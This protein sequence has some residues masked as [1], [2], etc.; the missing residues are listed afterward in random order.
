MG[1]TLD[2]RPARVGAGDRLGLTLFFAAAL[3][4]IIILGISFR[5]DDATPPDVPLTM[6]VTLVHSHS[7]QAPEKADYLA[8]AHQEG[9]GHGQ[10][11]GP[12]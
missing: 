10:Q 1:T 8:Q 7:D 6:E 12:P 2:H 3:H 11:T 5:P 4:A 9:G